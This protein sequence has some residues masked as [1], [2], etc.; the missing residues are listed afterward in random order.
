MPL[1][2][3]AF[4]PCVRKKVGPYK[5]LWVLQRFSKVFRWE[6]WTSPLESPVIRSFEDPHKVNLSLGPAE[7]G[8]KLL[9][10]SLGPAEGGTSGRDI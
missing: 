10:L 8:T 6:G 2:C 7:G 3:Y 5:A 1:C 4:V 9:N